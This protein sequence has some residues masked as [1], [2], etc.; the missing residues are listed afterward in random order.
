MAGRKRLAAGGLREICHRCPLHDRDDQAESAFRG[1]SQGQDG[2]Q[3]VGFDDP[4]A[5]LVDGHG[6]MN[7]VPMGQKDALGKARRPRG[8]DQGSGIVFTDGRK[9]GL[10]R[11][12]FIALRPP[13]RLGH[14]G[15]I[16]Q[17]DHQRREAAAPLPPRWTGTWPKRTPPGCRTSPGS[18]ARPAGGIHA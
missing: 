18:G 12:R 4:A 6:V 11:H 3:P 10:G 8:E 16:L 15:Q 1:M 13:R 14:D 17:P 7:Q 5:H 9:P 2:Q